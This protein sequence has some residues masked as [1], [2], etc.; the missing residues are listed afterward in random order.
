MRKV[1]YILGQLDDHDIDWLTKNGRRQ[2]FAA[3][4]K[5]IEQG[6]RNDNFYIVIDGHLDVSVEGIG[7]VA[8]FGV[9][10][11]VGEMSFVDSMPP[12]ATITGKDAGA[13]LRIDMEDMR[14]ELEDNVGFS[15]RF[16]RAL[17]LFLADRLRTFQKRSALGKD[18]H[19]GGEDALE[20]ELDESLLDSVSYAGENF[21]RM[22]QRLSGG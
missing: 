16:Y 4:E 9:G 10:E 19:L 5:L 17:S 20:D 3:G 2:A 8:E 1:L 18:G 14:E 21:N 15:G 13:V 22:I 6:V 7:S 12:S 11:I